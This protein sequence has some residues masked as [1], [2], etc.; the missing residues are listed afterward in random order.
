MKSTGSLNKAI[1]L[2]R[3]LATKTDEACNKLKQKG[4]QS[5]TVAN[6]PVAQDNPGKP[7]IQYEPAKPEAIQDNPWMDVSINGS[8]Q[9]NRVAS[10][11]AGS[12]LFGS[13]DTISS[14]VLEERKSSKTVKLV[15]AL[16]KTGRLILKSTRFTLKSISLVVIVS[17]TLPINLGISIIMSSLETALVIVVIIVA[18]PLSLASC[19]C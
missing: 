18:I 10:T 4:A 5:C 17:V 6:L 16:K 13:T 11:L 15:R 12:T 3:K 8:R 19:L 1:K 2:A 7:T 14:L 9:T